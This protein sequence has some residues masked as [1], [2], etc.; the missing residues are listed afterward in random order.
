MDKAITILKTH[1]SLLEATH[2]MSNPNDEFI[3]GLHYGSEGELAN[4]IEMLEKIMED[5]SYYCNCNYET[6]N[7]DHKPP[8]KKKQNEGQK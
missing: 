5:E 1:L 3:K 8:K 6:C 4:V 2:K 7:F